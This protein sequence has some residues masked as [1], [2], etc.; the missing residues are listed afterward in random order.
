[1]TDFANVM[2]FSGIDEVEASRSGCGPMMA[3]HEGKWGWLSVLFIS[4]VDR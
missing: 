3:A 1:M 2:N 4:I